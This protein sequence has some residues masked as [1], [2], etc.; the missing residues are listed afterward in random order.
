MEQEVAKFLLDALHI[1]IGDGIGKLIGLLYSVVA[2]RI[3]CLLP[4]PRALLTQLIHH[5]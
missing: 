1:L 2:Q 4:I 3:E 5:I